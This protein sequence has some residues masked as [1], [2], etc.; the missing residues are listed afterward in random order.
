MASS[1]EHARQAET[2]TIELREHRVSNP[3]DDST[4]TIGQATP[5][6]S[7]LESPTWKII[8]CAYSF[9]ISGVNDGVFGPLVPYI[10]RNFRLST[11]ELAYLYV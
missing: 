10:L 6:E 7:P 3:L 9:F 11:G 4:V 5:D 1:S 2:S 8:T